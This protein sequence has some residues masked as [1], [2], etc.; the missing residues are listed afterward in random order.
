MRGCTNMA[1]TVSYRI[2]WSCLSS[3][4]YIQ[5]KGSGEEQGWLWYTTIKAMSIL[6]LVRF[7][8]R[9]IALAMW[10]GDSWGCRQV[11]RL[12]QK[13]PSADFRVHT[14]HSRPHRFVARR[15]SCSELLS[16]SFGDERPC[17]CKLH[18]S[19]R[20]SKSNAYSRAPTSY[21]LPPDLK[22]FPPL[23]HRPS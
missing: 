9:T 13:I 4:L 7:F 22:A 18:A 5:P 1:M 20:S 10:Q 14:N 6:F 19:A 2:V 8:D 23:H 12:P 11:C 16:Q 21:T 15:R 3:K 17:F